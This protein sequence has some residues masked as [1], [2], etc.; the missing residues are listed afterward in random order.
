MST[1][2]NTNYI[3]T[4]LQVYEGREY[5][6]TLDFSSKYPYTAPTVKFNTPCYHPNV[7]QHGNICLDILKVNAIAHLHCTLVVHNDENLF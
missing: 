7:D 1:S 5:K 2:T 4:F 3:I 6:L